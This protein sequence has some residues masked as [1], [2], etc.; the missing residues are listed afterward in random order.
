MMACKKFWKVRHEGLVY[1]WRC[2]GSSVSVYERS[3]EGLKYLR[4]VKLKDLPK[5][6]K[7][8]LLKK[9][10]A[11]AYGE[12]VAEA[13]VLEPKIVRRCKSTSWLG[14]LARAEELKQ[15][16]GVKY[17]ALKELEKAI[18][19]K[20]VE[21]LMRSG[22]LPLIKC[23]DKYVL[24]DLEALL[25]YAEARDM[26]DKIAEESGG[27]ESQLLETLVEA[28]VAKKYK[29]LYVMPKSAVALFRLSEEVLKRVF[30]VDDKVFLAMPQRFED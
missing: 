28:G 21:Q 4:S 27:E 3:K 23:A 17:V 24:V 6:I 11:Y 20:T 10:V 16:K 9:I 2:R 8:R 5:H 14:Y 13:L 7:L 18:G 29:K 26:L 25:K 30:F 19:R 12:A 22:E 1:Q 15:F